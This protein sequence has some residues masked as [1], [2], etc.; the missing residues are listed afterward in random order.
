MNKY[1]C[2]ACG[3][4]YDPDTGDPENGFPAGTAFE[5]LPADW[6]CPECGSAKSQFAKPG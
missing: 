6:I 2:Q 5:E 3:C 1:Q 4:V